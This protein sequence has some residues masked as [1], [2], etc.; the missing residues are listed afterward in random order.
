MPFEA[1]GSCGCPRLEQRKDGL[2]FRALRTVE[3]DDGDLQFSS[4]GLLRLPSG[5]GFCLGRLAGRLT[6]LT[7]QDSVRTPC[8]PLSP[9]ARCP[10]RPAIN[11]TRAT[12]NYFL[13][14]E[15][16]EPGAERSS[17]REPSALWA[18]AAPDSPNRCHWS[19]TLAFWR[20]ARVP[21]PVTH[22]GSAQSAGS[23]LP[24]KERRHKNARR[25]ATTP[26][27]VASAT[28][29]RW[30]VTLATRRGFFYVERR[31][32]RYERFPQNRFP[33]WKINRS[34]VSCADRCSADTGLSTAS[35]VLEP[36]PSAVRTL[37][38]V[39]SLR[40]WV[41]G[42]V[43]GLGNLRKRSG[44]RLK[45]ERR[46]GWASSSLFTEAGRLP[47]A[48]QLLQRLKTNISVAAPKLSEG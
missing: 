4:F 5:G 47:A 30:G 45:D 13:L 40:V 42:V 19:L 10:L 8:F 16:V 48:Q 21:A 32:F 14:H 23:C 31:F 29:K 15:G 3:A 24:R 2:P 27:A 25:P 7:A 35:L 6:T 18:R 38:T 20:M 17:P 39:C 46:Q 44:A 26:G 22:P 43:P 11:L 37:R 28:P 36:P 12:A 33:D 41:E 9:E 34:T 1:K